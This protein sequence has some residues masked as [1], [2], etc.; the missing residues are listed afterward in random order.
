MECAFCKGTLE[1]RLIQYVQQFEG[2]VFIIENVPAEVCTQC[3]E[4][5]IH[6]EVADKIQKIV[7][8]APAPQRS[9]QV[10]VYDLSEVA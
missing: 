10:P 8:N 1:Q 5:L 7:W 2:R 4:S 9:T 6:P 3:G